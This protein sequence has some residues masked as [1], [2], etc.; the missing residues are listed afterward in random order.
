[1]A[2][3]AAEAAVSTLEP[4]GP[5]VELAWA[6]ATFANQRMLYADHDTAMGLARRAQE[7]AERLGA[8]AVLSDALN[9]EAARAAAKGQD[10]VDRMTRA[11]EIAR[12]GGHGDQ[13]GRA[14]TNLCA[15]SVDHREFA[16]AQRYLA[17]GIAYC[18]EHDITTYAT[19]LRGERSSLLERVGRWDEA[20]A[21]GRELLKKAG[22]SPANRLCALI[23]IGAITARRGEP[24]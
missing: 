22:R 3:A 10:W 14:Y 1:D 9:T 24:D 18:D 21:L 20:V 8:T 5:S 4:L 19:C 7:L 2:V 13:A 23:R 15:I 17:E 6:Y 11:L 12:A 16:A